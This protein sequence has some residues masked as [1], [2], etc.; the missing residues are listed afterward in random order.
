MIVEEL[1]DFEPA[2]LFV[3]LRHIIRADVRVYLKYEAYNPG[4][5]VKFRPAVGLVRLGRFWSGGEAAPP[6]VGS[7]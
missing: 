4:G 6:G 1:M 3:R 2:P 5:S 7:R